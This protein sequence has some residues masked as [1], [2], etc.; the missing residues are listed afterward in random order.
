[1]LSHIMCA[2][3]HAVLVLRIG[4]L[5]DA[6]AHREQLQ[7]QQPSQTRLRMSCC[8]YDLSGLT[9]FVVRAQE[10][11]GLSDLCQEFLASTCSVYA[12]VF[13]A[14]LIQAIAD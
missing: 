8:G 13:P 1:M 10:F 2:C 12:C 3:L 9:Y 11:I 4:D 5:I 7:Q 14:N 6:R